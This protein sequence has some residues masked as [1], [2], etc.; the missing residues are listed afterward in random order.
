[1]VSPKRL[2]I[3]N[4]CMIDYR[5]TPESLKFCVQVG[6]DKLPPWITFKVIQLLQAFRNVIFPPSVKQL[7][8]FQL[9]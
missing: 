7:T 3:T 5:Y 8:R 6:Y 2:R 9:T 1:M 4:E